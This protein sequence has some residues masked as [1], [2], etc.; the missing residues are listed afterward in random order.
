MTKHC[1]FT[2][3]F[4]LMGTTGALA[5]DSSAVQSTLT[6]TNLNYVWT[7]FAAILVFFMQAGFALLETGLTRSKNAVNIIMKNFMDVSAGGFGA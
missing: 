1:L 2:L 3:A 4:L 5:A 7:M 6:Q